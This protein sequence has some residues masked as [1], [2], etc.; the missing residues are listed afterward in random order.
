[1]GYPPPSHLLD[2]RIHTEEQNKRYGE[3]SQNAPHVHPGH[4][5]PFTNWCTHS[6]TGHDQNTMTMHKLERV[7]WRLRSKHP[8]RKRVTNKELRI[9]I[10]N[11]IGLSP[12]TYKRNRSVLVRHGW[13][14]TDGNFVI[15]TGADL[16]GET[17][18]ETV[19]PSGKG[20]VDMIVPDRE[21]DEVTDDAGA[22]GDDLPECLHHNGDGKDGVC[23]NCQRF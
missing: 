4:P 8:G 13:I 7:M 20:G 5:V 18:S 23:T 10:E 22:S 19:S 9:E 17:R 21:R 1:M 15:I 2:S 11:E 12:Q 6:E 3:T 16:T 14:K